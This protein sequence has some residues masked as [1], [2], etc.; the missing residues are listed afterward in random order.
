MA[1][2]LPIAFWVVVACAVAVCV[3]GIDRLFPSFFDRMLGPH[4]DDG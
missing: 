2:A 4:D 1:L 3:W